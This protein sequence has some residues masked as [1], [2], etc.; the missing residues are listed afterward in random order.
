MSFSKRWRLAC[1]SSRP[2]QEMPAGSCNTAK[3][4]WSWQ[5]R[6]H[7]AWPS[8]WFNWRVRVRCERTLGKQAAD[9]S[10]R[11]TITNRSRADSWPS[12]KVLP[13]KEKGPP[14]LKCYSVTCPPGKLRPSP[15]HCS[16]RACSVIPAPERLG[17]ECETGKLDPMLNLS[18]LKVCFLAG[19]LEHGGAERQLFY[20]LQALCRAGAVP[21]LLSMDQGQF[22]E[23]TIK[24]LGVCVTCVGG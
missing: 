8:S 19:T 20:I 18:K 21:R 5:E 14:C 1:R 3:P 9:G 22:W 2:R 12:F 16:S 17:L 24:A 6:I 23:E 15:G 13:G 4:A 11:N 7:K 10:S